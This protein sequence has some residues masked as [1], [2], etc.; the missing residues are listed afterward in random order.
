ML[1]LPTYYC[2]ALVPIPVP[3]DNNPKHQTQSNTRITWGRIFEGVYKLEADGVKFQEKQIHFTCFFFTALES[4]NA[5]EH[6]AFGK[7]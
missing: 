7:S 2:Q 6:L 3:L 5:N 4:V 1:L